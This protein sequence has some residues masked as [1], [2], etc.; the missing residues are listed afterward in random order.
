[1]ALRS[2]FQ[3]RWAGHFRLPGPKR[4]WAERMA[5]DQ[6]VIDAGVAVCQG[7]WQPRYPTAQA[8]QPLPPLGLWAEE[9]RTQVMSQVMKD[10]CTIML[11]NPVN[12]FSAFGS[13]A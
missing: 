10:H 1:M 6:R 4:G 7:W 2:T 3:R 5:K 9:V 12:L 8:I 11:V 13:P